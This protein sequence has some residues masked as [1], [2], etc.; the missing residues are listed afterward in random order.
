MY[1][2]PAA[3]EDLADLLY[4]I[5]KERLNRKDGHVAVKWLERAYDALTAQEFDRLSQDAVEL[6]LSIMHHLGTFRSWV[7]SVF[8]LSPFIVRALLAL[9]T[10]GGRERARDIVGLL[11]IV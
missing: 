3:A 4:E 9:Q 10:H 1:T 6:R 7:G 8:L 11:E 5:G 2:R